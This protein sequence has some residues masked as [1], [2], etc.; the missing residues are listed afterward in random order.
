[1]GVC[2]LRYIVEKVMVIM[3]VETREI[4]V[5]GEGR[6]RWLGWGWCWWGRYGGWGKGRV[7]H[8]IDPSNFLDEFFL[9]KFKSYAN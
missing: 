3:C 2:E 7:S 4:T 6:S 8:E 5:G 9:P 1:M